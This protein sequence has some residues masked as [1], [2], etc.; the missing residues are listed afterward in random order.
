MRYWW[1]NQN[2]TY[3]H[4]VKGGFLWSPKFS[5]NNVRNQFYENMTLVQPGDLV[6]SFCDT[7]IKAVGIA[8]GIAESAT[9]PEFGTVGD[10]WS[11]EGW[12]VPV[13]FEVVD[14]P[15][16]PKDFIVELLPHL[17]EK[18]A[19][20]QA[21][22]NGN[23]GVYLAEVSSGFA[24][25]VLGKIGPSAGGY[26]A[27]EPVD[28]AGEAEDEQAQITV[29]GRTDIG[30]TQKD[31]L[32]LARRGQGVF[33]ANVRLNESSCRMTGVTDAHFLVASHIKPWRDCTDQEKLDGCNGLLLSPH[34]DR[35][36]DRGWISFADDGAV[37]KS[38][39]LP[40]AVWT[41]W[42]LDG[43]AKVASFSAM[44]AVFLSYHRAQ[45]LKL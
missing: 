14:H 15:V 31:Q 9:K 27:S 33:R 18:Y 39:R 13:E 11:D 36:F 20:L 16:R 41:A 23:Q 19:P 26:V 25:V 4:E 17:P 35:L 2:Q 40:S 28:T 21:N 30:A 22:G 29:Q 34:I 44:Q 5:K 1:V 38:G 24:A 7:A 37:L 10:Q 6:F 43:V 45:V 8:Q 32:V 42:G 3:K 12:Y